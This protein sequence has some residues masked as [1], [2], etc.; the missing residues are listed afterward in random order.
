[1]HGYSYAHNNPA[2]WSD[3]TG[4]CIVLCTALLVG[5]IAGILTYGYQTYEN[6]QEGMSFWDAVY[7][8]NHDWEMTAKISVGAAALAGTGAWGISA[9]TAEGTSLTVGSIVFS[10]IISGATTNIAGNA[11]TGAYDRPFE[12]AVFKMGTDAI[13][14]GVGGHVLGKIGALKDVAIWQRGVYIGG[15]NATQG[16][17]NRI[18]DHSL[19]GDEE[20]LDQIIE[21]TLFDFGLGFG[22]SVGIETFARQWSLRFAKGEYRTSV[23]LDDVVEQAPRWRIGRIRFS[24]FAENTKRV[25]LADTRVVM[26]NS[27]RA[28]NHKP[29]RVLVEEA[30]RMLFGDAARQG[31]QKLLDTTVMETLGILFNTNIVNPVVQPYVL[32]VLARVAE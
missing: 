29:T 10:P 5:A 16:T 2:N 25:T 31:T 15:V 13:I 32:A 21:K 1:M 24:R 8:E 9:L 28:T 12:D 18:T 20:A 6:T 3:P 14:G 17:V 26:A 19:H 11:L 22:V 23:D 7:Y 4:E 27:P 30:Q